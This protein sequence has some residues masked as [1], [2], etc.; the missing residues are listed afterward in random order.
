[1]SAPRLEID[2]DKLHHNASTL[3]ER[4]AARGISVTGVTKATMGSPEIAY[5][6]FSA[7]VNT[8]GDSR[9][10][11]I[12]AMHRAGAAATMSLIRSP[13]LSQ[14]ER[15]ARYA[16]ISFNSELE[17]I[18]KLSSAAQKVK[19]RHGVVLMVELGDLREGIMPGDLEQT[20]RELLHLPNLVLKGIGTNLA[21][22]NGV[23]PDDRNM[24]EL[25]ALADSIEAKFGL[26]LDIVSGGN[27]ANLDWVLGS[28]DLGRINN[29]RLGESILLGC[30]PLH[31]Q[32]IEGLHT[33][34]ITLVT[35]VIESK[36]KPSQ[37]WGELGQT[38]FGESAPPT[39]HNGHITQAILAIGQQD[40]DP[41]GLQAPAGIKIL[42]ASSDHLIVNSGRCYQPVGSEIRFQ[43]NYSAMLRAM[44]SPFVEKV[45]VE[46][47]GKRCEK[48]PA[49][50][51]N[52]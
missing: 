34:A 51:I 2:L 42:G 17:V 7:G 23:T 20:V 12:E 28:S 18:R 52:F 14:V 49:L 44:T 46:K 30:E 31:R 32:P 35:E 13:M 22:R 40:T 1:M 36:V 16:D 21:C 25:S 15:V 5:T 33:D 26:S 10:E 43:L 41:D 11:N 45:M 3:V 8:L 50:K 38:A 27:S 29:L 24:A 19:R 37:P 47:S 48:E 6:L 9:I 4:L 39:S